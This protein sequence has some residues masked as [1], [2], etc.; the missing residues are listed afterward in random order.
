MASLRDEFRYLES[1][2]HGAYFRGYCGEHESECD[3]AI[4][5]AGTPLCKLVTEPSIHPL[6]SL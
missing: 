1:A 6:N 2:L 3:G 5:L 4:Q